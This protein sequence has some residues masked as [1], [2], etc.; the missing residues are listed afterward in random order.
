MTAKTKPTANGDRQ[1]ST[2]QV[3]HGIPVS[4]NQVIHGQNNLLGYSGYIAIL[5]TPNNNLVPG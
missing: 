2:N 4:T 3:I 1:I 5:P